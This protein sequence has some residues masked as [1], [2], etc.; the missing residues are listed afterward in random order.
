MTFRDLSLQNGYTFEREANAQ[1]FIESNGQITL[2]HADENMLRGSAQATTDYQWQIDFTAL[3]NSRC[4]CGAYLA[5][6]NNGTANYTKLCTHQIAGVISADNGAPIVAKAEV[7]RQ[8][9][10][11]G[12]PRTQ[13][14]NETNTS[15]P[16]QSQAFHAKLERDINRAVIKGIVD[17]I[18]AEWSC[19]RIPFLIGLPGLGKTIGSGM[20]VN[21][22]G[23]TR[24]V[25]VECTQSL[26]DADAVGFKKDNEN[27]VPGFIA[28]AFGL[29]RDN[30][31]SVVILV[32][33]LAR[34]NKRTQDVFLA[35][36]TPISAAS[37]KL[38]GI[39]TDEPVYIV[40]APLWGTEWAP[41]SRIKWIMGANPWGA[42]FDPA[43]MDRIAPVEINYDP[44]VLKHFDDKLKAAI[45]KIWE[46]AGNGSLPLPLTY[47]GISQARNGSDK[48]IFDL[49]LRK[50]KPLN[51]Q[52]YC[53]VLDYLVSIGLITQPQNTAANMSDDLT[54]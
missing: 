24:F 18:L 35:A 14:S 19:N 42:T 33:E 7:N 53:T 44:D 16:V 22:I 39:D 12:T 13:R 23:F 40:K 27:K 6:H 37:A 15:T 11:P 17:P 25:T 3:A 38:Q 34:A 8:P 48:S 26:T 10:Q 9:R 5:S 54:V 49:Y 21:T 30:G 28:T 32:D 1:K 20:T 41:V 36:L 52:A 45:L 29:A 4:T 43:F 2:H 46:M 31:E 51:Y 47:R 50:L